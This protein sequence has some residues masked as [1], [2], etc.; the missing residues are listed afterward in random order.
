M[1]C[2]L[3]EHVCS[4]CGHT[5]HAPHLTGG[6]GS[7]LVRSE[8]TGEPAVVDMFDNA[9]AKDVADLVDRFTSGLG[10]RRAG[11]VGRQVIAAAA[12][13]DASGAAFSVTAPPR[14]PTCA[15]TA[16][17]SWRAIDSFVELDLRPATFERFSGLTGQ[18]RVELV[19]QL[20]NDA[21]SS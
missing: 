16:A 2:Q 15:S 1:R 17:E 8:A 6:Y 19:G 12:D 7:W 11:D 20:V 13:P 3:A 14:C 21:L 5:F 9:Q 18:E 4:R 10:D